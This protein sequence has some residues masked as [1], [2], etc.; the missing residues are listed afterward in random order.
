MKVEIKRVSIVK[1]LFSVF[2]LAVFAVMLL[3]ALTELFS[4][5]V[6]FNLTSLMVMIM[7]SIQGTILFLVSTALFLLVYNGL[8][9]LGIRGVQVELEDK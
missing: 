2:P 5:E 4:P 8:C 1:V 6:S 9:A 7:R 3:S